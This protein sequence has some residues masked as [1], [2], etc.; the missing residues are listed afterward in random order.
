MEPLWKQTPIS[1]AIL[2]ISFGFLSKSALPPGSPHRAL[3]ERDAPFLEP[4]FIPLLKSPVYEHHSRFSSEVME[5][6]R[7][8]DPF[9]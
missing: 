7:W 6:E 8:L 2:S 5:V 3:S 9:S 1:R 4:F